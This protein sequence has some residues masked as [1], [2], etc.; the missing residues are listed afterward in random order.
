MNFGTFQMHQKETEN[1]LSFEVKLRLQQE[2][3]SHEVLSLKQYFCCSTQ[4]SEET[5]RLFL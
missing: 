5:L 4:K 3:V 1:R 2:K